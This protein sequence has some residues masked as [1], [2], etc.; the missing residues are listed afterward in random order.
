MLKGAA[1]R[2]QH[3]RCS[4][5]LFVHHTITSRSLDTQPSLHHLQSRIQVAPQI[6]LSKSA[7]MQFTTF[8]AL[9]SATGAFAVELSPLKRQTLVKVPCNEMGMK[10]CGEVCIDL[11]STC[12]P[13]RAGGCDLGFYCNPTGG[14]EYGC[15]PLGEVCTGPGGATTYETT[16]TIISTIVDTAT[17]PV[18]GPTKVPEETTEVPEEP[19]EVP[20]E[21]TEVPEETTEIVE[22]PETTVPPVDLPSPIPSNG[23]SK[24]TE[25]D[26]E[27][28]IVTG[29]AAVRDL[30]L[31]SVIGGLIGAAGLLL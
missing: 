27:T 15:C 23:T 30:G 1:C 14:G 4:Q 18:V 21:P 28:P 26:E 2:L 10:N 20:E 6:I 13:N 29:G 17:Y 19:T 22:V 3:V 7:T 12:C 24:P 16:D 8:L 31:G 25:T 5:R 11:S 9:A